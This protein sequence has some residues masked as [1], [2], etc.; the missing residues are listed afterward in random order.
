MPGLQT[1]HNNRGNI[2]MAS[3]Q[4]SGF[5]LLLHIPG[6]TDARPISQGE[7]ISDFFVEN[8]FFDSL[9]QGDDAYFFIFGSSTGGSTMV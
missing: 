5:R 7:E 2:A 3:P 4:R 6:F 1:A 8:D 9:F